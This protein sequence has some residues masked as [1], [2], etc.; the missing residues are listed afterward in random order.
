MLFGGWCRSFVYRSSA[1][2]CFLA[3]A[4]GIGSLVT[5]LLVA[6]RL[7]IE[8][9]FALLEIV[10]RLFCQLRSSAWVRLP[11]VGTGLR[12]AA[13]PGKIAT[14]AL[15][16]AAYGIAVPSLTRTLNVVS[17]IMPVARR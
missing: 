9:L 4:R 2:F 16:V 11:E 12:L 8:L 6:L 5:N 13:G 14:I 15:A 7:P 1:A 3:R 17:M 10:I